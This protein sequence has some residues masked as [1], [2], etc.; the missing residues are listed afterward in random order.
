MSA[1]LKARLQR[2]SFPGNIRELQN[3][4]AAAVLV[5]ESEWLDPASVASTLPE[6]ADAPG[7]DPDLFLP[8]AEIE[9][10]HI[11]RVLDAT[12]GDRGRAAEI[13]GIY[14]STVYRKIKRLGL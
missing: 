4:I 1:G 9:R 8:L 5:E 2:Y 14:P 11:R 13:L 6:T 7:D 10:R 12:Q 3:I